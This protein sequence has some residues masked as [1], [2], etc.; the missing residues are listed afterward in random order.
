M[1]IFFFF[2][3][4][5]SKLIK[6]NLAENCSRVG[7]LFWFTEGWGTR[8]TRWY[9]TEV[10]NPPADAGDW[11]DLG[12]IPG[13]GRLPG[14][15]NDNAP[16]IS[17]W[18]IPW[19]EEPGGLQS[20]GSQRVRYDRSYL[21]HEH[22]VLTRSIHV[23]HGGNDHR[24]TFFLSDWGRL[25]AKTRGGRTQAGCRLVHIP[26]FLGG[27]GSTELSQGGRMVPIPRPLCISCFPVSSRRPC[28]VVGPFCLTDTSPESSKRACAS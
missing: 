13:P 22:K 10:K 16:S 8:N 19:T 3:V 18:R 26:G 12:S 21:A 27:S 11:R 20:M 6:S 2:L 1:V 25:T 17:A 14:G 9:G 4:N 28:C 23:H 5:K 7:K 15:G 24:K